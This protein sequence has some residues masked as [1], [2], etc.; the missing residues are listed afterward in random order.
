M[1]HEMMG[2]SIDQIVVLISSEDGANQIFV[3]HPLEFVPELK[4]VIDVYY[5]ANPKHLLTTDE[6]SQTLFS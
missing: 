2:E 3:K 5:K 1:W 6:S 4:R